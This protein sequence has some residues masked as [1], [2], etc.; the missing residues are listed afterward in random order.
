MA[1]QSFVGSM[2]NGRQAMF[3]DCEAL[4]S[5]V[6]GLQYETFTPM[7]CISLPWTV[8]LWHITSTSYYLTVQESKSRSMSVY[9]IKSYNRMEA[10]KS[11]PQT[12]HFGL[13][14]HRITENLGEMLEAPSPGAFKFGLS[15]IPC[16][17]QDRPKRDGHNTWPC[18]N[19]IHEHQCLEKLSSNKI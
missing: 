17:I 9:T 4:D 6:I 1:Q 12:W 8:F 14:I 7:C 13:F 19:T 10:R 15:K 5:A 18:L 11:L 16:L 2:G 3:W